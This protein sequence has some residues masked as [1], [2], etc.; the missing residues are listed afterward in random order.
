[1]EEPCYIKGVQKQPFER[2][3][4]ITVLENYAKFT[5]KHLFNKVAGLD[6]L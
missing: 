3:S 2:F 4:K 1:M 6:R 5:E